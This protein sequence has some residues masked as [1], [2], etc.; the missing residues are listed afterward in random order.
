[1]Q[2]ENS[3]LRVCTCGHT[4]LDHM[5]MYVDYTGNDNTLDHCRV[6]DCNCGKFDL[7][8]PLEVRKCARCGNSHKVDPLSIAAHC[9]AVQEVSFTPDGSIGHIIFSN[10]IVTILES[11]DS[12]ARKFNQLDDIVTMLVK[13]QNQHNDL[14][15]TCEH[16]KSHHVDGEGYCFA[17][18]GLDDN[19]Q[20][21]KCPCKR[22]DIAR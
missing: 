1:M 8:K 16:K 18:M 9:S 4:E 20:E 3:L 7:V 10:A 17:F 19:H 12:M 6:S 14:T 13:E 2:N 11:L 22:F 5:A 21:K 15:C